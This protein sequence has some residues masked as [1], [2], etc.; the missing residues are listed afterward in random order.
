MKIFSNLVFSQPLLPCLMTLSEEGMAT[1][2]KWLHVAFPT[3]APMNS[4]KQ[5]RVVPVIFNL[6]EW[7]QPPRFWQQSL[8]WGS[9]V[10]SNDACFLFVKV[11]LQYST[12]S[13]GVCSSNKPWTFFNTFCGSNVKAYFELFLASR[14]AHLILAQHCHWLVGVHS[15]GRIE[16]GTMETTGAWDGHLR[17]PC[18]NTFHEKILERSLALAST[19]S[20]IMAVKSGV[21]LQTWN[22]VMAAFWD[23]QKGCSSHLGQSEPTRLD[24]LQYEGIWHYLEDHPS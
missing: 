10:I 5:I 4:R 2:T 7:E 16:A 21:L 17:A 11:L 6:T 23:S 8:A 13:H 12:T 18:H 24:I 15:S 9:T 22:S 14:S 3:V 19:K 20:A 1:C